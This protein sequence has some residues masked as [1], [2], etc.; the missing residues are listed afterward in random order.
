[1]NLS[2][3]GVILGLVLLFVLCMKGINVYVVSISAGLLVAVF[4]ALSGSE[5]G[6]YDAMMTHY[7]GG[8]GGFLGRYFFLFLFGSIFGKL[9]DITGAAYSIATAIVKLFGKSK[10]VIALII[11]VGCLAYGGLNGFVAIFASL[12]VMTKV[13]K[14]SNLPRRFMPA[15]YLFGAGTFANAG[16]GSPQMLNIICTQ[17]VGL[18]PSGGLVAGIVG[19]GVV[20]VV[21]TVWLMRII[22]KAVAAGEQFDVRSTD[23]E[24]DDSRKIPMWLQAVLPLVVVILGINL[25]INGVALFKV[26]VGLV[27]GCISVMICC[28]NC[29]EWQKV[30]GHIGDGCSNAIMMVGSVAAMTG[31]GTL[32]TNS[33]AYQVIIDFATG[34][35]FSPLIT[36]AIAMNIMCAITATASGA[37]GIIAP[38]LGPL[39]V[40]MGLNPN[41]VARVMAISATG[42]DSVPHNGTISAIINNICYETYE[43][44]YPTIFKLCVLTPL[45]GTVFAIITS[46]IIY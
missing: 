13:F 43:S 16:P 32:V 46:V 34:L 29:V 45:I 21:G 7:G 23:V 40:N 38:A 35:P 10:A 25:K 33:P 5:L 11:A 4:S 14:E 41:A 18:E 17:A 1:M 27:I 30:L 44:A 8:F 15:L 42:F 20:F 3:I 37:C 19:S 31:F 22:K 26:E 28:F 2:V 24:W 9:M 6:V 39:F 36:L 12:P